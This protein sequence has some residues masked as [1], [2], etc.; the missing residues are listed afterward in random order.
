M[1]VFLALNQTLFNKPF[2]VL[3]TKFIHILNFVHIHIHKNGSRWAG[4]F[5]QALDIPDDF[6]GEVTSLILQIV[7]TLYVFY[8][9]RLNA[10]MLFDSIFIL[11]NNT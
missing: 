2:I 3:S 4:V 11:K 5:M 9:H 8:A 7:H 6:L 10:F 1:N